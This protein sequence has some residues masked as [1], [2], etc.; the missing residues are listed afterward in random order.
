MSDLK[1]DFEYFVSNQKELVQKYNGKYIVIKDRQVVG[2]F[3]S[4]LDAY[5]DASS[6]YTAGTFLIQPCRPGEESYTQTFYSR[7]TL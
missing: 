3:D 5:A 7:V 1:A 6:K 4:E 2:A